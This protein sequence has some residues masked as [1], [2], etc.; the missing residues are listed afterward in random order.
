[1]VLPNKCAEINNRSYVYHSPSTSLPNLVYNLM[2]T[3]INIFRRIKLSG[4]I[5]FT[6]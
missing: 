2:R 3:K 5:R 6:V 1:M 4:L